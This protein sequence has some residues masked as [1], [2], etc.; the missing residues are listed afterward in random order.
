M[1]KS[2]QRRFAQFRSSILDPFLVNFGEILDR[3]MYKILKLTSMTNLVVYLDRKEVFF[4]TKCRT[5]IECYF[6]TSRI[7]L[8]CIFEQ[9]SERFKGFSD[10]RNSRIISFGDEKRRKNQRQIRGLIFEHFC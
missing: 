8:K 5:K 7:I 1:Q 3:K 9:P 2:P 4:A 6:N 10:M